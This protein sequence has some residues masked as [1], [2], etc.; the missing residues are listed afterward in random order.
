MDRRQ[1]TKL[2]GDPEL[3]EYIRRQA[4]RHFP[5]REDWEDARDCAWEKITAHGCRLTVSEAKKLAYRAIKNAYDRALYRRK[6]A[7][8]IVLPEYE[9]EHDS[10][11]PDEKTRTDL[12]RAK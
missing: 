6:R 3:N 1:L 12:V 10:E 9:S 11:Q 7:G 8:E 5:I 2:W 4:R